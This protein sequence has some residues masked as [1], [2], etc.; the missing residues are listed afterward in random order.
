MN[1]SVNRKTAS[2]VIR[3][4]YLN[5]V[6]WMYIIILFTLI[7]GVTW[8]IYKAYL[9]FKNNAWQEI[10]MDAFIILLVATVSISAY[11]KVKFMIQKRGEANERLY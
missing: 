1:Q 2:D 3:E 10:G 7:A 5:T 9:Y 6:R 11:K 4:L 8:I